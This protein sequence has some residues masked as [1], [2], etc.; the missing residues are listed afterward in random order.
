MNK[1]VLFSFSMFMFVNGCEKNNTLDDDVVNRQSDIIR[2]E[3]RSGVGVWGKIGTG[4][5]LG[6]AWGF[7]FDGDGI[8][9]ILISGTYSEGKS[10]TTMWWLQYYKDGAWHEV[11]DTPFMY[12]KDWEVYYRKDDDMTLPRLFKRDGVESVSAIFFDREKGTVT[13][14]PFDYGEFYD[15]QKRKIIKPY[16]DVGQDDLE[17]YTRVENDNLPPRETISPQWFYK[18]GFEDSVEAISVV[19][20]DGFV[21]TNEPFDFQKFNDLRKRGLLRRTK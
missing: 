19:S 7:D 16:E 17:V 11:P 8:K 2:N 9:E 14:E 21:T 13:L 4:E 5:F 6:T 20:W 15:L 12:A 1:F 10:T 3:I 18:K